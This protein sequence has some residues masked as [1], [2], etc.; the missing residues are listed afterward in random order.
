MLIC[1][2]PQR[3]P[4]PRQLQNRQ[5]KILPLRPIHPAR[6]KDHLS[7]ATLRQRPLPSQL[8]GPVDTHR[9]VASVSRYGAVA[10]PSNT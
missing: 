2:H 6:P 8:A 9:P 7:G 3:I 1:H 4:L 10:N 5:Q